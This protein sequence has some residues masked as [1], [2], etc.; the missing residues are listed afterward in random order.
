MHTHLVDEAVGD[1]QVQP[2]R[3]GRVRPADAVLSQR[4]HQDSKIA[5]RPRGVQLVHHI[6]HAVQQARAGNP[7]LQKGIMSCDIACACVIARMCANAGC[8]WYIM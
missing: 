5:V 2:P 1:L 6:V 8:N 3:W 7:A 4:Q